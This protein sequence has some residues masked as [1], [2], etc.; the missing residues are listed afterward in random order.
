MRSLGSGHIFISYC[1]VLFLWY[2]AI[3]VVFLEIYFLY[4]YIISV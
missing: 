1:V 3:K 4:S 2:N